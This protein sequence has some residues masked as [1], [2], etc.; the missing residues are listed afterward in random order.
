M[1]DCLKDLYRNRAGELKATMLALAE[2]EAQTKAVIAK[3]AKARRKAAR[4]LRDRLAEKLGNP[5][6]GTAADKALEDEERKELQQA[7][8]DYQMRKKE[9]MDELEAKHLKREGAAIGQLREEHVD[10]RKRILVKYLP[11]DDDIQ[12]IVS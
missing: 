1:Q 7:D 2:Q 12:G 9:V 8:N 11:D 4:E 10:D 6:D 3:N 5:I